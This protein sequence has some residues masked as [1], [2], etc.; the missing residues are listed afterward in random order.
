MRSEPYRE[1]RAEI[2]EAVVKAARAHAAHGRT[3]GL[4]FQR[5]AVGEIEAQ[6][7]RCGVVGAA[8]DQRGKIIVGLIER[9]VFGAHVRRGATQTVADL[10]IPCGTVVLAGNA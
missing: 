5:N 2:I 10:C 4:D 8:T 7:Q 3:A 9:C 1:L 6:L